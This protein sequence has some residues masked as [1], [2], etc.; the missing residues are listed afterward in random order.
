MTKEM[1][2]MD[3]T[4]AAAAI[5]CAVVLLLWAAAI[6]LLQVLG[7]LKYADWQPVPLAALLMSAESQNLY[8][9]EF[10]GWSALAIVPALTDH[11]ADPQS[12]LRG[13]DIVLRWV[14][15]LPLTGCMLAASLACF[16]FATYLEKSS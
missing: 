12:G 3:R 7:W 13:L 16:W 5:V 2:G 14:L 1:N 8:V 10:Q 4:M 6:L 9:R 11:A 15:D